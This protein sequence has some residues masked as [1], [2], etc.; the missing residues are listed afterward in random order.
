MV[1]SQAEPKTIFIFVVAFLV[2]ILIPTIPVLG[3]T[4][5]N[6]KIMN[7]SELKNIKKVFFSGV[8]K[9]NSNKKEEQVLLNLPN[10]E[11]SESFRALKANLDFIN[12]D[13]H[14]QIYLVTSSF[15]GEGKSFIS[16]N[17]AHTL[18]SSNKKVALVDFDLRKPSIH[19]KVKLNHHF[20]GISNFLAGKEN[21]ENIINSSEIQNLSFIL[22]GSLPPN[23]SEL[24]TSERTT[25]LLNKLRDIYDYIVIDTPPI[26]I[27]TDANY[28]LKLSDIAIF[29]TRQNF[30]S[31]KGF[32]QSI[33]DTIEM[34][35]GKITTVLN[36]YRY[37][38]A[39]SDYH[40]YNSYKNYYTNSSNK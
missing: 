37:S 25:I 38:K 22:S 14:R 40:S 15:T 3:N 35:P 8:I 19:K 23:P 20:P 31:I 10:S 24:I 34:F 11:I 28:L 9:H 1:L 16:T 21:L 30:T 33:S 13:S 4:M 29:V 5:L 7:K 39:N 36:D 12:P 32:E 18:A 2:G 17:L 26:G 27:V 6:T